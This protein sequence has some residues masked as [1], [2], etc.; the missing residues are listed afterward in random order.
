MSRRLLRSALLLGLL[1]AAVR[2][3]A[4]AS[5]PRDTLVAITGVTV[6]D[7]E[8]GRHL[9]DR[10][11]LVRGGRIASVDPAAR[12]RVPAAARRVDG[13]GRYLMPGLWDMHVHVSGIP[14]RYLPL[15]LAHGVTGAREMHEPMG[16]DS[17]R[18][19]RRA[20]ADGRRPGPRLVFAGPLVDGEGSRWPGAAVA[21]TPEAGRRLVDSLRAGGADYVKVYNLLRPEVHAAIAA[22]AREVGLPVDGHAPQLV[23]MAAASD[24]GQRTL[25][26]LPP[27]DVRL[28]CSPRGAEL[29]AA[30]GATTVRPPAEWARALEASQDS[31]RCTA[32]WARLARN[33]TWV[34]PTI[35]NDLTRQLPAV[36]R[37]RSDRWRWVP[38]SVRAVFDSVTR[39]AAPGDT[40]LAA[41]ARMRWGLAT[42]PRM[43]AAGVR[44]L[45][46][47]DCTTARVNVCG[48][49]L[50]DELALLAAHGLTPAEA[51]RAAT[52]E[53]ARV[54]GA[55]DTLGTVAA[56]RVA[57]LVL[58]DADPLADVRNTTR[59][60]AV[61]AAG[62]LY[63]R[64]ALD[65]LLAAAASAAPR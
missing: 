58:L 45:A 40:V 57:D 15:L 59:I 10:T 43:R 50:H 55:T 21:A 64:R 42:L 63:D 4:A 47:T 14:D 29:R 11:V 44:L 2:A 32:F 41:N 48:P 17:L 6:V 65:A 1:P 13:R 36:A 3:Q 28:E 12:A 34:T 51:L 62:R 39:A 52:L 38:D 19:W 35:V 30:R 54:F 33:G 37:A 23:G 8:Q 16:L 20:I 5:V 60:R 56:G 31:T 7:V 24:A 49:A 53:P 18:A 9:R 25:E 46:G 26:H 61:I 22:R 27:D